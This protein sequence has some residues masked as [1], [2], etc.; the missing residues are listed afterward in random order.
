MVTKNY[1]AVWTQ[2]FLSSA[3]R[4]HNDDDE[5]D[6][7]RCDELRAKVP[8]A[9]SDDRQTCRHRR[10][11]ELHAYVQ[12]TAHHYDRTATSNTRMEQGNDERTCAEIRQNYIH[13]QS[14]FVSCTTHQPL[15]SLPVHDIIVSVIMNQCTR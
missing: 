1:V 8:C 5:D 13:T 6:D 4:A 9:S 2:G 12:F 11:V 10:R 3:T 7:R 15:D 14:L